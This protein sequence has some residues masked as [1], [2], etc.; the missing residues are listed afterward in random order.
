M[1]SPKRIP[2]WRKNSV[3]LSM[4]LQRMCFLRLNSKILTFKISFFP[5]FLIFIVFNCSWSMLLVFQICL[6]LTFISIY[7]N[8]RFGMQTFEIYSR[9]VFVIHS[10]NGKRNSI[11]MLLKMIYSDDYHKWIVELVLI[12]V[13]S[14]IERALN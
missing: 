14:I 5:L 7:C 9:I 13:I 1:Q 4:R 12:L 8:S 3:V 10:T 2:R 6:P 11:V